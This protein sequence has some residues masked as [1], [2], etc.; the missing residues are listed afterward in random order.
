MVHP[1]SD[2]LLEAS[3]RDKSDLSR[4]KVKIVISLRLSVANVIAITSIEC[5]FTEAG[6]NLVAD[7]MRD[8]L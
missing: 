2:N 3:S 5:D 1:D 8:N 6:S 7:D 4:E